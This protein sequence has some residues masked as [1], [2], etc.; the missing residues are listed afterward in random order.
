MN[1]ETIRREQF[2]VTREILYFQHAGVSPLPVSSARKGQEQIEDQVRGGASSHSRWGAIT[3][4]AR[5]RFAALIGAE[6]EEVA[7]VKSTS[8]GLSYVAGGLRWRQGDNVVTISCEFPSNLY[9]WLALEKQGVE[10]RMVRPEGGRIPAEKLFEAADGKT[11]LMAVSS[12]EFGNG[13]RTDLGRIGGMCRKRGILLCVDAI[14][15]LGVLPMNVKDFQIDFLSAGG[16]KW[17]MSLQGL[18]G[19]YVSKRMMDAMPPIEY[20]W[21]SVKRRFEF[22]T[23]DFTLDETAKRYEPSPAGH[24][25]TA[26][27]SESLRF[28]MDLGIDEIRRRVFGLIDRLVSG[29]DPSWKVLSSLAEGERSGILTFAVPGHHPAALARELLARKV[30]VAARGGGLRV[31]PH[32]YNTEEEIDAFIGILKE[33]IRSSG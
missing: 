13:F 10:T 22:E 4:E 23:I 25:A 18:G 12:V 6:K 9:P 2:P 32:F 8:E 27:F 7:F 1:I 29:L 11:R 24:V 26:V 15:S 31:S 20:G 3:E 19:F 5:E 28:L 14:Q 16:H 21:F 33:I 17:L 30:V